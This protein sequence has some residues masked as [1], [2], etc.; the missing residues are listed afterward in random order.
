MAGF[1]TILNFID[2]I[3]NVV[4]YVSSKILPPFFIEN[5]EKFV[6]SFEY[7]RLFITTAIV[8]VYF[9]CLTLYELGKNNPIGSRPEDYAA[10]L[11]PEML[12]FA[13]YLFSEWFVIG[14]LTL[15]LGGFLISLWFLKEIPLSY[16]IT[17]GVYLVSFPLLFAKFYFS[18]SFPTSAVNVYTF[19]ILI[20][21]LFTLFNLLGNAKT[22][23]FKGSYSLY[24]FLGILCLIPS[25][26][27]GGFLLYCGKF[28]S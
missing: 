20:N 1:K 9:I 15:S 27:F 17:A 10:S 16:I 8:I 2:Y 7:R 5:L 3:K 6:G 22:G 13:P 26:A 18:F 28:V 21:T 19:N 24:V 25:F 23:S 11:A 14:G 4:G 12:A